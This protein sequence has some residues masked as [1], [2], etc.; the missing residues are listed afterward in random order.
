MA[1]V[2]NRRSDTHI[3]R[4]NNKKLI[5]GNTVNQHSF[6]CMKNVKRSLELSSQFFLQQQQQQMCHNCLP[7]FFFNRGFVVN[8]SQLVKHEIKTLQI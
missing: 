7:F 6:V 1:A 4:D 8:S 2:K 3:N 5:A